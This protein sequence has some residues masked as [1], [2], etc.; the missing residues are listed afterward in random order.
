LKEQYGDRRRTLIVQT[1]DG[2]RTKVLTAS[3]LTPEKDVWVTLTA[4]GDLAR[5]STARLPRMSGSSAPILV[6]GARTRDTL[7]LFAADGQ[8][9]AVPVHTI[10]ETDD[11][12]QGRQLSGLTP[13]SSGAEV[14]AGVALSNDRLQ[15][16]EGTSYLVF[17]TK[18]GVVKKTDVTQLP[19][20]A[21]RTFLGIKIAKG[22]ALGWVTFTDGK[23]D[24]ILV[25]SQ[26]QAIRF[27]ESDVRPMGLTAAGVNGMKLQGT[28]DTVIGAASTA[29]GA[30]LLIVTADGQA[31]R[32]TLK[33]Y[34]RQG[35]YGK[36][37]ITWKSDD[38]VELSGAA[39]G[40]EKDRA[41]IRFSRGAPRSLRFGDAPR[42][43]R[44]SVGK[45]LFEIGANNRVKSI[46]PTSA[47]PVQDA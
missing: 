32:T 16:K 11:P 20:P 43:A 13:F 23:S 29:E 22:D 12:R 14:I 27:S 3:D 47:R 19:G 4:K 6:L 10:P 8:G 34:P 28:K 9:S 5:T 30:E 36:G 33:Q 37:V 40:E 24:L 46:S 17:V 41:V 15:A 2:K 7:Y 31:K 38:Q 1:K 35:R 21:S 39:L 45:Q 25:S 18:S 44:A 42:R 26:R